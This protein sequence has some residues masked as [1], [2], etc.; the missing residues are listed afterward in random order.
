M[1][2]GT[3]LS[4]CRSVCLIPS[5]CLSV[6]LSVS[7]GCPIKTGICPI[8]SLFPEKGEKLHP[9][10][11][12]FMGQRYTFLGHPL[13][14]RSLSSWKFYAT[15]SLVIL[16]SSIESR[17]LISFSYVR[18]WP[19]L[20]RIYHILLSVLARSLR[21]DGLWDAAVHMLEGGNQLRICL[22]GV[23][24]DLFG[25][26]RGKSHSSDAVHRMAW[27]RSTRRPSRLPSIHFQGKTIFIVFYVALL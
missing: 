21:D 25:D 2:S 3:N 20:I 4:V 12:L 6:C 9:N 7:I 23:H 1:S 24:F 27:P 18:Y 8:K 16:S 5:V 19:I 14:T 10:T 11:Y 17:Y 26:E 15:N 13:C 22:S